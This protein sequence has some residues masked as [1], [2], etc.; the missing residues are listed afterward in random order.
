M[1]KKYSIKS[2]N[3]LGHSD[4]APLRKQDPGE[5]FPWKKLSK[6]NIGIWYSPL[7]KK[8]N[9]RLNKNLKVL[10]FSKLI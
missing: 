6:F 8:L 7:D 2:E 5:K 9:F 1:K 4:I 10:F 3:F